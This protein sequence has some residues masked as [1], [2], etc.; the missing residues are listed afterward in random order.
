MFLGRDVA[1]HAC[2]VIG[3][4]RRT[5]AARDVI[6]AGEDVR[7]EWPEHVEGR[8]VTERAL[9][10]HVVFDLIERNVPGPSTITWQPLRQALSV[11]PPSTWA[12]HRVARRRWHLPDH[13][14]R[15][16]SPSENETSYS[17]MTSQMSS[18]SVYI[19]SSPGHG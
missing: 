1:E 8:A 6:V 3:G 13:P 19:G 2:A 14:G 16:P 18:N 10:L 15:S 11:K 9:E 7:H 17:R 4:R 12:L 5:N